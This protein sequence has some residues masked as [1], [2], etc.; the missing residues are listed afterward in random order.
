ML[1]AYKALVATGKVSESAFLESV[2]YI[3]RDHARTP[4]QWYNG[5]NAGFTSGRPWLKVNPNYTQTNVADQQVRDD[6][7]LSF[8]KRLI[9]WRRKTPVIW[10]GTYKDLSP[11]HPSVWVYE[12][13][14]G[15]ERILVLANF[16]DGDVYVPE[17]EAG[18]VVVSNYA[19]SSFLLRPYESRILISYT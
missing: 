1:N 8:Y 4:M 9:R 15:E 6:S 5:P 18:E 13:T 14:L 12:R 16:S 19:G 10:E 11:D 7:I 17:L 2:N 3:A